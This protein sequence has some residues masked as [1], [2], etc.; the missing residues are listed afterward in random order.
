MILVTVA[1][2]V[3]LLVGRSLSHMDRAAKSFK[4]SGQRRVSF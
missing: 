3:D 2:L 4:I 1:E